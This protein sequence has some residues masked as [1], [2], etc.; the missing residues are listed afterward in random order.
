L[1]EESNSPHEVHGRGRENECRS[2]DPIQ[3]K[4]AQNASRFPLY[5]PKDLVCA[6]DWGNGSLSLIVSLLLVSFSL[7][8]W[9]RRPSPAPRF[10]H[11][12]SSFSRGFS[13]SRRQGLGG[14]GGADLVLDLGLDE[15]MLGTYV[16]FSPL[17]A[18]NQAAPQKMTVTMRPMMGAQLHFVSGLLCWRLEVARN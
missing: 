3:Y 2:P 12:A 14:G 15:E 5:V 1:C 18:R 8:K 4:L 7:L 16:W 11:T 17:G 13:S 9:T 6:I 10:L